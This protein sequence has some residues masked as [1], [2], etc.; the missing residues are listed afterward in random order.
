MSSS[1]TSKRREHPDTD[2]PHQQHSGLRGTGPGEV[3]DE[4]M[5]EL[6]DRQ[7]EHEVEEELERGDRPH[8]LLLTG[9]AHDRLLGVARL[10][11]CTT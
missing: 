1:V 10:H 6:A 4:V 11:C 3:L 2:H 5:G 7:H 8:A 9:V